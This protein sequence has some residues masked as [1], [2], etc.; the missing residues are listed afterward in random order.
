MPN[1]KNKTQSKI[2]NAT[3][4]GI[5]LSFGI[6]FGAILA[7]I[8]GLILDNLSMGIL[9]T[10]SIGI[11]VCLSIGLALDQNKKIT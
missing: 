1:N 5:V 7:V 3:K 10:C 4:I 11:A 8:F 6:S 2:G 9:I